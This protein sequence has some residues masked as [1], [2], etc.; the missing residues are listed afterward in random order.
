MTAGPLDPERLAEARAIANMAQGVLDR[1]VEGF[2]RAGVSLPERRF[3]KTGSPVS[4][5]EQV[6]V[7]FRQAYIG[8][9][10]DEASE[11]QRCEGPRSAALEVHITRCIPVPRGTKQTA[12]SPE[13]IQES[14]EQQMID[15]WLLLDLAPSTDQWDQFGGPGLG[16]IAT[17]EAGEAQGGMQSTVLN[18]TMAIP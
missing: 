1:V 7:V 9:P 17:V 10:G 18:L 5:C 14:S 6:V 11:P 13:S 12:P 2:E 15:A 4:D 3:T 8:P 16:V